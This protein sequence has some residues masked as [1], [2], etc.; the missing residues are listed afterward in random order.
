MEVGLRV[1]RGPD[2]MWGNQDGGEGNVGT[3]V[4]LGHDI[5]EDKTVLVYWD[6]G[7]QANYRAGLYGKFDLRVLDSAPTG[8]QHEHITC[9]GCRQSPIFGTRWKCI[10]CP[11][12]DLCSPCFMSDE[13]D[14][15]HSFVRIDQPH[16][17]GVPV[18]K[19]ANLTK[20]QSKGFFPG[21]QVT[22]GRDWKWDDQDGG[23]GRVGRLT[24]I[25]AW[26]GIVRSGAKVT[27]NPFL[28]NQ[29]RIGHMG[30]VDLKCSVA[31]TGATYYRE[32]LAKVGET[33]RRPES[34]RLKV[35]DRVTVCL[36]ADVL[37]AM[38]DGHGGWQADMAKY[39]GKI[40]T[41][42]RIDVDGDVHVSYGLQ[43][44]VF[45]PDAVTKVA[46]FEAGDKIRV[47]NDRQL[48]QNLQQGHGG[49]ND[50][51]N[52][53][54]GKEGKILEV[55]SDGDAVVLVG[56][57]LWLFNPAALEHLSGGEA[58]SRRG[59]TSPSSPD[60]AATRLFRMM[61]LD[62]VLKGGAGGAGGAD[63]GDRLVN[64]SSNGNFQDVRE[65]LEAHPDKIDYKRVGKTALHV[66]CHQ[67]RTDIVKYLLSKGAD[68]DVKDE[69]D[70]SPLHHA[71]YGDRTGETVTVMLNTGTNVNVC[72]NKNK[73]TPLQL[74][75]NQGNDAGVKA[76]L[77][78]RHCD[79]N[80]QD[81]AGDTPL[82]DAISKEKNTIVDLILQ[83]QVLDV[84]VCNARGFNPLHLASLKGNKHAVQK[85]SEKYPGLIEIPKEDGF[86]SL[87]LAAFNSHVEIARCLLLSGHCDINLR[88]AR[89]QT[90]LSL[91]ISE[92]F[93]D[94]IE[95]LIE[96]GADVNADDNDGDTPLHLAV[97][98]Q[99]MGATGV[100][101]L[102]QELG[103]DV[104]SGRTRDEHTASAIALYLVLHGAD[105]N[106]Y[107]HEGKTPLDLCL[108]QEKANLLQ[109]VARTRPRQTPLLTTYTRP[110][111]PPRLQAMPRPPAPPSS[112]A[113]S[114]FGRPRPAPPIQRPL[115]P[116]AA[117]SAAS[118]AQMQRKV[119]DPVNRAES[120][121]THCIVCSENEAT[122]TVHPCGHKVT[123]AVCSLKLKRC[124]KCNSQI[125]Q[126]ATAEDAPASG[127][128]I[129]DATDMAREIQRLE[130]RLQE[131][132]D[133]IQC[134]I[135]MERDKTVVFL[136]GH[137]AC[138]QC[139]DR[140][141]ICHI[142]RVEIQNRIQMY[143]S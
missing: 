71:A 27:W 94:M 58:S 22:R 11:N 39:I 77:T 18:G 50:S 84:T 104:P 81:L 36:E 136:C 17:N 40:G 74:A 97:M 135:C 134:S 119:Q 82:H 8:R 61:L 99:A 92:A 24:D 117:A 103:I 30:S 72:D 129:M 6:S 109:Q 23:S 137:G 140:L 142:C 54:L 120:A 76:L 107:N 49:W 42:T 79:V 14:R 91:A 3:V 4:H 55:D 73:S 47:L 101:G 121:G 63:P 86:T 16:G 12:Y 5:F 113:M 83:S 60:D 67:G 51:M 89:G 141:Q 44:W 132:E 102:L 122:V 33:Y 133:T 10:D 127:P 87:H 78:S 41:I 37:R 115:Q 98:H 105:L 69:Q 56:T 138:H 38:S 124:L 93:T 108:D 96:H 34:C 21:A 65:I 128:T 25:T 75:V 59:E 95:L 13:H 62:A 2:W 53:A 70:Y 46:S 57:D 85:I 66:A 35:G 131:R 114:R 116:V 15:N 125:Q 111:P 29:Y 45:H 139:S 118:A 43:S 100:R 90:A 28:K 68:K 143:H 20:V 106:F 9:D 26:S 32:C 112:A 1:V 130:A 123:C 80:R 110:P 19:R 52:A 31:A 126:K 64:A 7:T 88:N 48:V